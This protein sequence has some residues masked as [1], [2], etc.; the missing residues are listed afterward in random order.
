MRRYGIITALALL[1][2]VN[3][4][5]LAGVAYNRSGEPDAVIT[6]TERELGLQYHYRNARKEN[7][8]VALSLSW[9][10][11]G[12]FN[13]SYYDMPYPW[14]DLA[15]LQA[16]GFDCS[17]PLASPEAEKHY[18][19]TR[20]RKVFAVLENNG[21]AYEAYRKTIEKKLA[22]LIAKST[23]TAEKEKKGDRYERERLEKELKTGSRLFVVDVGVDPSILR[24]Q[25]SDQAKYIITP[26]EV[27]LQYR[28]ERSNDKTKKQEPAK[29]YGEISKILIN[30]VHV[31]KEHGELLYNIRK[32]DDLAPKK[33]LASKVED[34][35][36]RYKVVLHYGQ[37]YEPWITDIQPLE[38]QNNGKE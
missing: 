29:L 26:A 2:I 23:N 38:K 22:E 28:K 33:S 13:E 14:F 36:P 19:K 30:T 5:V 20:S 10:Q 35:R 24:Q 7:S 18:W 8:G 21:A 15:K 4:I 34:I 1:A 27:R 3:V 31:T 32:S 6:L 11:Y 16:V 9:H 25:Y 12:H 37:R 17:I